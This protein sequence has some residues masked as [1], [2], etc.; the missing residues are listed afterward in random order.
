MFI[1]D[2]NHDLRRLVIPQIS[3]ADIL[4]PLDQIAL[5]QKLDDSSEYW[6]HM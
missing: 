3:V 5:I 6:A 1:L 4:K 2:K